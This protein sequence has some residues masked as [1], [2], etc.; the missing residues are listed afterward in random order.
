MGELRH[1]PDHF[2]PELGIHLLRGA[3]GLGREA[4]QTAIPRFASGG[5]QGYLA[6]L[7]PFPTG[8]SA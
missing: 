3:A 7:P 4:I 5:L 1:R 8:H 6:E 2:S